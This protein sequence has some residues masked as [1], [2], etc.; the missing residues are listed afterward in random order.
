M[1]KG[2][3]QLCPGCKEPLRGNGE[4]PRCGYFENSE[5][6]IKYLQPGTT[7]SKGRYLVGGIKSKNG[8]GATYIGFDRQSRSSCWIR[9]YFPTKLARRDVLT[10]RVS[11]TEG[12]D[13]QYKALVSDFVDVCN[14]VKR[15]AVTE[16]VIPI[17]NEFTDNN[18]VYVVYK[19]MDVIS[20]DDYLAEKGGK[21]PF[22]RALDIFLPFCNMVGN[23]HNTGYIHRGISPY[24]V[25]VDGSGA[26]YLWDFSI[27]AARTAN[28][29]LEAELFNGYSAPEQY[30]SNGWQGTWTDVYAL[31][32]LFYRITSGFVPPKSTL[33]GSGRP[34]TDLD[35]IV[36]DMPKNISE[37]VRSAI[38]SKAENRTQSVYSFISGLIG[39]KNSGT[40]VYDTIKT[41]QQQPRRRERAEKDGGFKYAIVALLLTVVVLIGSVWYIMT[42]FFP[43]MMDQP[44]S[45]PTS[46]SSPEPSRT[47]GEDQESEAS[48]EENPVVP[49]FIGE[50]LSSVEA[51]VSYKSR[52]NFVKKEE[53]ND[54]FPAGMIYDQS[55][56]ENTPMPEYGTVILYVSRGPELVTMPNIIG[57]SFDDALKTLGENDLS[58]EK[59]DRHVAGAEPGAVVGTIPA[60]GEEFNPKKQQI[61]LFVMPEQ[62]QSEQDG[63]ESSSK[64]ESGGESKSSSSSKKSSS[65]SKKASSSSKNSSGTSDGGITIN[66]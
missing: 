12:C 39:D 31:A 37:A 50:T 46:E 5:Y 52:Y 26:L 30:S 49:G 18:T 61:S 66:K 33:V 40:A 35:A 51:N 60:P 58:C 7:L 2:D 62:T 48:E 24:T 43:N 17:I 38:D 54:D 28:S 1:L 16:R 32:A 4:C 20:M 23:I 22:G 44:D 64:Q 21:L 15:L 45:R 47:D 41:R 36:A 55:P 57:L 13:A 27:G 42:A 8:E 14:E 56:Q 29:E 25:Y 59:I 65:S 34:V 3:S 63:G 53:Y 10:G 9:E 11:P 19:K 6:D